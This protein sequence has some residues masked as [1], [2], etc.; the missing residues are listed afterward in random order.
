MTSPEFTTKYTLSTCKLLRGLDEL[1]DRKLLCDVHLVAEDATFPAHRV[2]LAAASPYFQAMF[3][4]GFKENELNEIV[5]K[6]TSSKGLKCILDAIYSAELLLSEKDVSDVLP[7]A[8]HFQLNEV[9]DFCERFLYGNVTVQNC[10]SF[11]SVAEKFDLQE[12]V[13]KCNTFVLNNFD[14]VSQATKFLDI[15]RAQFCSYISDDRLKA[16]NGE[17]EVYKATLR[18][19]EGQSKCRH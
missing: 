16:R 15:S 4:G 7:V 14:V 11:L 2:I 5:L 17:I 3:T 19:F 10:L 6:D 12:A 1:R 13:E 18:W 9:V 8:S